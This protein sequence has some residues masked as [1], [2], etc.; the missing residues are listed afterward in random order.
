MINAIHRFHGHNGLS[1]VYQRGQNVRG[2][3]ISLKFRQRESRWPYRAAVVVS[4][5]VSR[6]AP[7]RNR[8]RRRIYEAVRQNAGDIKPGTDLVFTVF[9]Q[10]V[11]GLE[12]PKLQSAI[13]ELL[14]KAAVIDN[15]G[16]QTP[17]GRDIVEGK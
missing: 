9:D 15:N 10:K 3:L 1:G 7:V 16:R 12:A 13:V 11:A 2:P 4:R 6:S 5:K 8:I 17:V 14:Q